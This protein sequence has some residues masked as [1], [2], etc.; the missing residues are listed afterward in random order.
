[1]RGNFRNDK[2]TRPGQGNGWL[3]LN[4]TTSAVAAV[5]GSVLSGYNPF[6]GFRQE[7]PF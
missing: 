6:P 3:C 5:N 1:M 4:S 2:A 7:S